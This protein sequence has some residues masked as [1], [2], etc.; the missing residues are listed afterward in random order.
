MYFYNKML[1]LD[2]DIL[3]QTSTGI[4]FTTERLGQGGL[5]GIVVYDKYS[6]EGSLL[7]SNELDPDNEDYILWRFTSSL[8]TFGAE[9]RTKVVLPADESDS[10][11]D[12]YWYLT[13]GDIDFYVWYN[14]GTGTDPAIS[15]RT[16]IEVTITTDAPASIVAVNT[17][18]ELNN[19][20]NFFSTASD[21]FITITASGDGN[22]ED[23]EDVD[24]GV[25]ISVLT[26]GR[27]DT[28]ALS[29]SNQTLYPKLRP[30]LRDYSI[31]RGLQFNITTEYEWDLVQSVLNRIDIVRRRY[32]NEGSRVLGMGFSGGYEKKFAMQEILDF[33]YQTVVEIN[34]HPPMTGAWFQFTIQ[35]STANSYNPYNNV[36]GV[37]YAWKE[38]VVLG[39]C[40]KA[41][42]ARQIFEIDTNF[43][44]SDQGLTISY[45]RDSKLGGMIG[46]MI[47]DYDVK[48]K[49]LKWNYVTNAGVRSFFGF[50]GSY[51]NFI[52]RHLQINGQL[53][54][55]SLSPIF[56]GG[57]P[58]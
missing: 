32:P 35:S 56:S 16:G 2:T 42:V 31:L 47:Q 13:A 41:L 14:T 48:K 12:T 40:I 20:G 26:Q 9:E 21:N 52:A 10:L 44:L 19:S 45:D 17:A 7:A 46:A 11:N 29:V 53:A 1:L 27:D 18:T 28:V 6:Q 50:S 49:K 57:R 51:L 54:I 38:T 37:P 8:A 15:G 24:S 3:S 55:S 5:R 25:I 36:F 39:A 34:L 58:S 30:N 43:N 4:V 23:A 22:V 33:I